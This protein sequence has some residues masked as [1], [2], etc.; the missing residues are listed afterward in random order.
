MNY[1]LATVWP[2]HQYTADK[3]EIIDV[4]II[5]PISRMIITYEPDNNPSGANATGHPARCITKIELVDGS[6]V[7][8]SLSGQQTQGVDFYTNMKV[9]PN[10]MCYLNGMYSEMI[11]N[12]NFG[13]S[14]FDPIMALDPRKFSNLQLKITMDIDA[15]GDESDDGYLTVLA[16]IFDQKEVTPTGFL[17]HKEIK[18]YTLANSAHEYTDLPTD[19]IYKQLYLAAQ[20]YGTGPEY[21][22]DTV[23]ISEDVDKKIP[24]NHTM[25]QILR[26]IVQDWPSYE[27]WILV[28]GLTAAQ[29]FYNT[30][31]Y[32]PGFTDT[33]WRAAVATA[34]ASCYV[35]DGGRFQHD[36]E[37]AGP[38]HMVFCRGWAPHAVVPLLPNFGD[39][40]ANWYD[41]ANIANL[42]ADVLA[43][44][45]VGSSQTAEIIT[46]Q[47]RNYV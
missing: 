40:P 41:V 46:Q 26:N 33:Q 10:I 18:Q 6:D 25:F 27:E 36:A 14:L 9:P 32:W 11:M 42:K 47:L 30:P 43:T 21:Q 31:C 24:L 20:R 13:R 22:I 2:R 39:D 37:A 16:Q 44:S 38:N 35:G 8:F 28:P 45:S 1:R 15:G 23:K 34:E 17:M 19:H 12:M 5:D 7:L 4:D 29:Y 3:T